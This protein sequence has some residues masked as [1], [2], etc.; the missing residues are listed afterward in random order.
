MDTHQALTVHDNDE[1]TTADPAGS[2]V[3][4][5]ENTAQVSRMIEALLF[6]ASEPLDEKTIRDRV[7]IE[8]D[9]QSVMEELSEFYSERGVNLVNISGKWSLRTASDLSFLMEK[10]RIEPRRLS[11]PAIETLAII[12]YHQPVSRAEIEDIRGVAVSKGTLDLLMEVGWVKPRGRRKVP[13]RPLTYGTSEAFLEHFGISTIGDLPGL[14]DLK[15]A[16]LLEARLPPD[17][18]VPNP[19]LAGKAA[20][21]ELDP[22]E[23][24]EEGVF[25]EDFLEDNET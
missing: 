13:G 17:F 24:G 23:E 6:A 5:L 15:A 3:E 21:E 14:E 4:T 2:N 16:G 7:P 25:Q 8:F 11:R 18:A 10:E 1:E 20:E 12:A 22:V 19:E 9:L